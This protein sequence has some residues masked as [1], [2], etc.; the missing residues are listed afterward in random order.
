MA[1]PVTSQIQI[2]TTPVTEFTDLTISQSL[3]GH[4]HF[5]LGIPY[6]AVEGTKGTFLSKAH[7]LFCGQRITVSI[8]LKEKVSGNAP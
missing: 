7:Q 4:H 8:A 2:G 5:S 6:D 3:F 1:L